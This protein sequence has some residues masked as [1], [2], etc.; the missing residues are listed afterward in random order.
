MTCEFPD[1]VPGHAERLAHRR[2]VD[3]VAR[4]QGFDEGVNVGFLG[5]SAQPPIDSLVDV[6][7][8][9][10]AGAGMPALAAV[11]RYHD[12]VIA[13]DHRLQG[14]PPQLAA[15]VGEAG[16]DVDRERRLL[17]L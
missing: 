3:A 14:E 2:H 7:L 16:G 17:R 11:D 12:A 8:L 13:G 10:G 9:G 5:Q 1:L 4:R 15:A 6:A